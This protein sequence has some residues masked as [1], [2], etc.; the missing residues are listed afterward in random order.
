MRILGFHQLQR[1]EL[2]VTQMIA[3]LDVPF[4]LDTER[5]KV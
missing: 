1:Y 2:I 5:H 3:A 4:V